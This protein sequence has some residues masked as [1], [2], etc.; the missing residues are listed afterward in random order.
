MITGWAGPAMAFPGCR[1]AV[2]EGVRQTVRRGR[3]HPGRQIIDELPQLAVIEGEP[4]RHPRDA[5]EQAVSPTV[6]YALG[7]QSFHRGH[8]GRLQRMEPGRDLVALIQGGLVHVPPGTSS[9]SIRAPPPPSVVVG[10]QRRH[11]GQVLVG[12]PPQHGRL[13]LEEGRRT[14]AEPYGAVR[15]VQSPDRRQVPGAPLPG[16]PRYRPVAGVGQR[17]GGPA[18]AV[19]GTTGPG[20]GRPEDG[21]PDRSASID[22]R[23][24]QVEGCAS[25]R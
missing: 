24:A 3:G 7:E 19:G 16:C 1:V 10:Q 25:A 22:P 6:R 9:S 18:Q 17:R 5:V 20:V 15:C 12:Q 14:S 11:S 21:L 13:V 4:S 8:R 2:D 23:Y